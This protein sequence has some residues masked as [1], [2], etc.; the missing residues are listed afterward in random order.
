M[1]RF[2]PLHLIPLALATIFI[3]GG[4]LPIWDG[5]RAIREYGL[6]EHIVLSRE[7]QA[8]F[9]IYG[10]RMTAWLCVIR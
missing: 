6:P 4:A 7:A 1:P 2:H 10:S 8:V 5:S 3:P 9:I